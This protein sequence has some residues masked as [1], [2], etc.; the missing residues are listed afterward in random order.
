MK[1]II[2]TLA[3]AFALSCHGDDFADNPAAEE[4]AQAALSYLNH[5]LN[6]D[7]DVEKHTALSPHCGLQRRKTIRERIAFLQKNDFRQGDTFSIESTRVKNSLAAV[8][9]RASNPA[10]PLS[11]H[12][13]AV[14]LVKDKDVWKPAP[15]PGSFTN[16]G[17]GYD[18][19]IELTVR[20]LE[21]W[22][23]REKILCETRSREKASAEFKTTVAAVEQKA[24]LDAMSPEEAVIHFL[25][26]CR[27]RNLFGILASMGAAS[28]QLLDPLD[29]TIDI[30]SQ[31]LRDSPKSSDWHLLTNRSVIAQ[32]L[33]EDHTRNEVAVGFLNPLERNASRILYFPIHKFEGKTFVRLA[34]ML[35]VALLPE[36][37]RR[38]QR[39]RNRHGD[40]N[41]L[42][43]ILPAAIFK[44]SRP[45]NYPTPQK[46]RAHFLRAVSNNDFT[47]AVRLLPRKGDYF[48]KEENQATTLSSFGSLWQ[49]ICVLTPPP[50]PAIDILQEKTIALAPLQYAKPNR[51]GEFQTI[52]IWMIKDSGGWHLIGQDPLEKTLRDTLNI[53]SDKLEERFSS[54]ERKQQEKH[55]RNWLGKVVT[56]TPPLTLDPIKE[57]EAKLLFTNFRTHLRTNKIESALSSCAVLKGTSS[58]HTL[59]V[60]N[61]AIRGAADHVDDD[62]LLGMIRAGKWLAVSA[63]TQSKLTGSQDYPLYLIVS[64]AKGPRILLDID[65]RHATNKGR[66]L[67]NK[68]NWR[69]LEESLPKE[70]LQHLKTLFAQHSKLALEDIAKTSEL[71]E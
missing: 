22:M 68:K 41:E 32:V 52:K 44:N 28:D 63:R 4:H 26:Q 16:T 36:N 66:A 23:A 64:T 60:F 31:G 56:L 15:L 10:A 6:G 47:D 33:K 21:H 17:Y 57:D 51:P 39:W 61:Y 43:K 58:T 54:I 45:V 29:T 5:L 38:A 19:Q 53:S 27:E 70:S 2:T 18:K 7:I 55:S 25:K 35:K 48:G 3:L 62:Q 1:R 30:V 67:L 9:V 50:L 59:K 12:I 34:P 13:H 65:L 11:D 14:A 71:R 49:S 24:G 42:K 40:E 8:L 46:L 20:S 69:T 37:E